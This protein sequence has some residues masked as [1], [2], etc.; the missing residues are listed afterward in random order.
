MA[1]KL[2]CFSVAQ[3]CPLLW[4]C[5]L[6][7]RTARLPCPSLSARACSNSSPSSQW[8]YPTIPSSVAPFSSCLQSFPAPAL[9]G[10][11]PVS[12]LFAS[13][14]QRIGT[15]VS[16]SVLPVN[17]QGRLPLG[18]TGLISLLSKGL[19][20]V[21]SSTSLKASV[22]WCSSFFIVQLSH[23]SHLSLPH[24]TGKIIALTVW[25]F[26]G[27]VM[28]L[29]F[30]MLSRFVIAFIWRSKHLLISWPQSPSPVILEPKKIK[31]VTVFIPPPPSICH[32]VMRLDAMIFVFWMLNFKPAFSTLLFHLHQEVLSSS[33]LSAIRVVS[34]SYWYSSQQSWFQL[35]LY[36]AWYFKW[37]SMDNPLILGYILIAIPNS[38]PTFP[39]IDKTSPCA[40]HEEAIKIQ[41]FKV[42]L[43]VSSMLI[44]I[45]DL[46]IS[47]QMVLL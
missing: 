36:P 38:R 32:N 8:C 40:G 29:L 37:C 22:L 33:L 25:T 16:P 9:T 7:H 39:A 24:L 27:K 26:V 18:L 30:N 4:P 31:S 28:S 11:Y 19:S 5:G 12:W 3:S 23:L 20:R 35:V 6:Q 17:I 44:C 45:L 15:S 42:K 14:G 43:I 13:G 21:F 1:I 41:C 10:S 46:P 2:I 47:I 34:S